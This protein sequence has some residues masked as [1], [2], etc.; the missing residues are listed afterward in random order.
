M[1]H[2]LIAIGLITTVFLIMSCKSKNK[3]KKIAPDSKRFILQKGGCFGTCPVYTL[4]I[5][6]NGEATFEG[7]MNTNKQGI[8]AKKISSEEVTKL[9]K[10]FK[11]AKFYQFEENYESRIADLPMIT[12]GFDNGSGMKLVSGKMERPEEVKQLQYALEKIAESDG[13]TM[14]TPPDE[15]PEAKAKQKENAII[16]NEVI[17]EPRP[18]L[19]LPKWFKSK[20]TI[21]VRLIKKIAPSL[22]YFLITYDSSVIAPEDFMKIL[23]DDPD[24]LSA[25]FNKKVSIRDHDR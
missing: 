19:M 12:I 9:E 2:I 21:G 10:L 5:N 24:I 20:S 15:T 13:W 14:I 6:Q 17:I 3:I 4:T 25:E 22:N 7:R 1:K 11:N 8:H 16:Y 23:K 18:G